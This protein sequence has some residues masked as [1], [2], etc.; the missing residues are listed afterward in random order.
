[1]ATK[2]VASATIKTLTVFVEKYTANWKLLIAE[3]MD[4][5]QPVVMESISFKHYEETK[6]FA[7]FKK[8]NPSSFQCKEFQLR[9]FAIEWYYC[10]QKLTH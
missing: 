3:L 8:P 4:R 1:M 9:N 6:L 10:K 7:F 2:Q 5:K